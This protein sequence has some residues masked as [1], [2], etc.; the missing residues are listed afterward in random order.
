MTRPNRAAFTLTELLVVITIIGLLMGL[1]LPAVQQV[2]NIARRMQCASRQQDLGSAVTQYMQAKTYFPGYYEY[3]PSY[4]Q[5]LT[6]AAVILPYMGRSDLWNQFT[7][8]PGGTTGVT[9][10][11]FNAFVCPVDSRS[12]VNYVTTGASSVSV[13]SYVVNSGQLDAGIT[14]TSTLPPDSIANGVFH[15]HGSFA[16]YISSMSG[17]VS[18]VNQGQPTMQA[19]VSLDDIKDGPAYTLMLSENLDAVSWV[20]GENVQPLNNSG[21]PQAWQP[22]PG[23]GTAPTYTAA[24][25][26]SV[27][28]LWVP[29]TATSATTYVAAP[30]GAYGPNGWANATDK[31]NPPPANTSYAYARPSSNHSGGVNVTYCDGHTQFLS[32]SIAYPVYAQL[33]TPQGA[34]AVSPGTT[35]SCW[36]SSPPVTPDPWQAPL[37]DSD[38]SGH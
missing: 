14:N 33:M 2:R 6:W 31:G 16:P 9:A 28:M 34:N 17:G 13:L 32:D 38:V 20:L 22:W 18:T 24:L 36:P 30:S 5:P 23:V 12:Q 27:S 19:F 10:V 1:L 29:P 21:Q 25:E 11:Y 35:S 7:T 4:R 8:S 26:P 37:S 15:N 3:F